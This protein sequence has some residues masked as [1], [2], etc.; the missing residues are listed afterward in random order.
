MPRPGPNPQL[1]LPRLQRHRLSNGLEV[2]VVP[3][4]EMPVV[5][6]NLVVKTGAD[7]DGRERAG[8]ASLTA[9][10]LDEGTR[11]RNA[12]ELSEQL[13]AIGAR[14]NTGA[15][16]DSSAANLLTVTRHMDRALELFADVILNPA[17]PENE[18]TRVRNTRLV[19]LQ[20]RRDDPNAIASLVYSSLLY[21]AEHPYGQPLIGTEA[22]VQRMRVEDMRRFY[23]TFYRPNNAAL[24]VVGDVDTR[25]LL[26]KLEQAFRSWQRGEVPATNIARPAPRERAGI[27]LVDRPE[28][29]QSVLN[30]GHVG[31]E[32]ATPDYFPL[33]VLNTILGGQFVSRVNLNLRENKGYTYGARTAFE[34]R[35]GPGPF[36]ASAGVQTAVTRESIIEFMRELR[37]IRGAIPIRPEE[38]EAGKQAIIRGYPRGFETPAQIAGRLE[39]IVLYNLPDDYFNTYIRRVQAVTMQDVSRVANRYLD[40]ARMAI[41]VVGDRRVVEPTLREIEGLGQT[42]TIIDTEGRVVSGQTNGNQ[43]GGERR[44]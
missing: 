2:L 1:Q 44:P 12:L 32:R 10:M 29:A 36:A 34:H 18:L 31:V 20:Q 15:G 40:P 23:E 30:I 37:G 4:R 5:T 28:S 26:P 42:I 16:W 39:D 33:L 14:I 19:A 27:Y 43:G 7:A 11:T 22:S 35:R 38:L 41:L 21:G 17:F 25:T 8:L 9:D 24:I 13:A 3:H 6:M